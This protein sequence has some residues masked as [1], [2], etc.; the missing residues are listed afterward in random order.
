MFSVKFSTPFILL[1]IAITISFTS[2]DKKEAPK[3]TA[4]KTS[5][6]VAN[7]E[8]SGNTLAY[9]EVD[10][11][12]TQ[13]E[14]CIKEKAA[15]EAKSKQYEAQINAKMSQFQKASVD[16]QQK[17]QSGAFTSQAQGEAAQQRLIRLQQEGAKLQQ[18]V[19]QR[20]LK[21]QEKFNKTL[22]DSVQSFLKDYNREKH[23]DMIISKQGDNV[24]YANDKLDITKE[25]VDGLNKRFKNRK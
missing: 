4:I 22:R 17:V 10:S 9:V 24:L 19:Q 11:L 5:N 16:F 15:L 14:F 13:Y 20:M 21:A 1:C 12:L 6:Q 25:V 3:G 8:T 2:C 23:Y 7:S 18:D